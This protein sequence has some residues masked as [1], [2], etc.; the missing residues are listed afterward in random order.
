MDSTTRSTAGC[1]GSRAVERRGR[2]EGRVPTWMGLLAALAVA[3][4]CAAPEAENHAQPD[5]TPPPPADLTDPLGQ[6]DSALA[7]ARQLRFAGADDEEAYHWAWDR[8][9]LDLVETDADGN[10]RVVRG[11]LGTIWPEVNS[12]ANSEQA[13]RRGRILAKI[14]VD[15]PYPKLGLPAGVSYV[16]VDDKPPPAEG[17]DMAQQGSEARPTH[18]AVII[19]ENPRDSAA[20]LPVYLLR[21]SQRVPLALARWRW[22]PD[23]EFAWFSCAANGCC[24]AR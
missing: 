17:E 9:H 16:W 4:A 8:Q 10:E 7:Y 1:P 22:S 6:R 2:F 18:R 24:E 5:G 20:V 11:P 19:P 3:A 15:A 12:H 13:L 14:H 23:D 21:Q